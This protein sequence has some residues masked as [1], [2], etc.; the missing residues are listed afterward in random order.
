VT[1]NSKGDDDCTAHVTRHQPV[2]EREQHAP[3]ARSQQAVRDRVADE[4]ERCDRRVPGIDA[5]LLPSRLQE[6]AIASPAASEQPS[7]HRAKR[8]APHAWTQNRLPGDR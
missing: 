7:T 2:Q 5:N 4:I 3:A 8:G 1:G 6:A